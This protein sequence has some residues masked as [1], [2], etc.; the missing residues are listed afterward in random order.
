MAGRERHFQFLKI[1][2]KSPLKQL[3][4]GVST[5]SGKWKTEEPTTTVFHATRSVINLLIG[6]CEGVLLHGTSPLLIFLPE[7]SEVVPAFCKALGVFWHLFQ[8]HGG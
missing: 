1:I 4:C 8:Q 7:A 5:A 2:Y 3:M 6:V